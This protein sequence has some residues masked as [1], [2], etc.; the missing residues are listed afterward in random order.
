MKT[1][2]FRTAN[3][4]V[5][6]NGTLNQFNPIRISKTLSLN[7][8]FIL[9]PRMRPRLQSGRFPIV[10]HLLLLLFKLEAYVMDS[11]VNGK[12]SPVLIRRPSLKTYNG[13]QVELHTFVT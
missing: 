7:S 9:T 5:P 11:A 4:S 12:V 6:L 8:V 1:G 3:K 13:V 2:T 10:F